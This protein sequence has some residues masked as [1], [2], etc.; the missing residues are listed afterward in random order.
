M[1]RVLAV[2]FYLML[3]VMFGSGQARAA[4]AAAQDA[5]TRMTIPVMVN[6]QGPFRFVV[7]TGADRTV[8]SR[9]LAT[10]LR[11]KPGAPVRLHDTAG[12][13][14]VGTV[15]VDRLAFGGREVLRVQAPLLEED[16]IGAAGML[17]IDSLH[18]QRVIMDFQAH[19]FAATTSQRRADLEDANAIVIYGHRRFGELVLVNATANGHRVF[20]ILDSGAQN[21]LGNAALQRLMSSSA[22]AREPPT[23]DVISAMGS[24][25][26]VRTNRIDEINLGGVELQ[27]VPIAYADLETF[28]QFG[29]QGEPAMLLGMDVLHLFRSVSVDFS[30]REAAF[31]PVR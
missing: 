26:P 6:G 11:L 22:A 10:L 1:G 9:G 15:V 25:T 30:R 2:G 17:G 5:A 16:N 14:E 18:D 4:V 31:V 28:R 21:T 13:A 23:N 20:V 12:A 7:D 8:I 27:N 29:L 3:A 19:T 24:T